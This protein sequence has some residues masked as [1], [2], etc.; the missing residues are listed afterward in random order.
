[1]RFLLLTLTVLGLHATTINYTT[2]GVVLDLDS[3]ITS[4]IVQNTG[5]TGG[6]Q[7]VAC[8]G[9]IGH[10]C[11]FR[12]YQ[13][14]TYRYTVGGS[15]A[16]NA[17][18]TAQMD[19][20][21]G[22]V[23]GVM[24]VDSGV[25]GQFYL[26]FTQP[27][28]LTSPFTIPLHAHG[29][30][31]YTQKLQFS[32]PG[33]EP[34][35]DLEVYLWV[36]NPRN[37]G[38]SVIG[39]SGVEHVLSTTDITSLS[40]DGVA[41]ATANTLTAHGLVA[42]QVTQLNFVNQYTSDNAAAPFNTT[43]TVGT[44]PTAKSLTFPCPNIYGG[45]PS[46]Q[47]NGS[48]NAGGLRDHGA[49]VGSPGF[50][51]IDE[52]KFFGG[53]NGY[54]G[55]LQMAQTTP[56]EWTAGATNTL[57][58]RFNG[59]RIG[60]QL[61]HG[62][63]YIPNVTHARQPITN[64]VVT[65]GNSAQVNM[66]IPSTWAVNDSVIL[67]NSPGGPH[68]WFDGCHVITA[69][70]GGRTSFTFTPGPTG[71][72]GWDRSGETLG[73][74][75]YTIPNATYVVP[76]TNDANWASQPVA[77]AAKALIP[78]SAFH[79]YDPTMESNFGGNSSNGSTVWA[80]TTKLK[81]PDTYI[82]NGATHNVSC[83]DCH[84][85]NSLDLA[86]FG[87]PS[88]AIYT[89][90]RHRGLSDS[91]ANDIVAFVVSKRS[92]VYGSPG[93]PWDAVN[94][95]AM[96]LDSLG[97]NAWSAG[98][99]W[100]WKL[101]YDQDMRQFVVP[102]GSY[103]SWKVNGSINTH[104]LPIVMDMPFWLEMLP[105]HHP[106]DWFY[107]A[108]GGQD[109]TTTT[110]ATAYTQYQ[111]A[112]ERVTLTSSVISTDLC[113]TV[114]SVA[115]ISVNDFLQVQNLG[116]DTG[117]EYIQVTAKNT[118]GLMTNTLTVTRHQK[119]TTAVAHS[120]GD[121]VSDY[122]TFLAGVA[123]ISNSGLATSY[124]TGSVNDWVNSIGLTSKNPSNAAA[125]QSTFGNFYL[126]GFLLSNVAH[127]W[128]I[129]NEFG[130][131]AMTDQSYASVYGGAG[132]ANCTPNA[133]ASAQYQVGW[134]IAQEPFNAGPHKLGGAAESLYGGLVTHPGIVSQIRWNVDTA[135]FYYW[136]TIPDV[137]DRCSLGNVT[138]D[139]PYNYSFASQYAVL[140]PSFYLELETSWIEPQNEMGWNTI[141]GTMNQVMPH[142][143]RLNF[144]LAQISPSGITSLFTPLSEYKDVIANGIA[145][146][147]A[148]AIGPIASSEWTT[149]LDAGGA[150]PVSPSPLA[151]FLGGGC[152]GDSWAY[153]LPYLR[154]A[155]AASGDT[156]TIV[157][158]GNT[159]DPGYNAFGTDLAA[160]CTSNVGTITTPPN[161]TCSNQNH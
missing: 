66:T 123:A 72:N 36:Y 148:S 112:F 157:N 101:N 21:N 118:C 50:Q 100:Q 9:G 126:G 17:P 90:S 159:S 141:T 146:S 104:E 95:P 43:F 139:M 82:P 124:T 116:T 152:Y 57:S 94:Q 78:C 3:G 106:K 6:S 51:F 137:G 62:F 114:S 8:P 77:T 103:A 16:C 49:T 40:C 125:F 156:T 144:P 151:S 133:R 67:V 96:G 24:K 79:N 128:E 68:W 155:G 84:T 81:D 60:D 105:Q 69:I 142:F 93:R 154:W 28:A 74:S 56:N 85:K 25:E 41:T 54:K 59:V 15:V 83:A 29:F 111:A 129:L 138:Q 107:Y 42:G 89:A 161:V 12:F 33:G 143:A 63:Y 70:A 11:H 18:C 158:Q 13:S 87:F 47:F 58:I 122:T 92:S 132:A 23:L 34:T 30:K 130:L 71:K 109:W 121:F 98:G 45:V 97:I 140:R 35:N 153:G 19:T 149:I 75:P 127:K 22:Q 44:V 134:P 48:A 10:V 113:F 115:N 32:I 110:V 65:G 20:E 46:A 120:S 108:L 7:A 99:G 31:G 160:T 119:G 52:M 14:D 61:A 102:G 88:Q 147:V 53:F 37:G 26:Q 86:Y 91:D 38:I 64:I 55:V 135:R 4:L 1:M 73:V 76:T 150:C 145:P 136:S 131:Q 39:N 117:R 80:D 5:P 27:S 2:D